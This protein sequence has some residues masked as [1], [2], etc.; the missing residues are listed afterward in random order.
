MIKVINDINGII[1]ALILI[2]IVTTVTTTIIIIIGKSLIQ[3]PGQTR[4]LSHGRQP[5]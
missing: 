3:K 1:L 5:V 4:L 2:I